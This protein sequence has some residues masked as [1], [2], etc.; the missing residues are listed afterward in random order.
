LPRKA[1]LGRPIASISAVRAS[2]LAR[3]R[4]YFKDE[5]LV[6]VGKTMVPLPLGLSHE[7]PVRDALLRLQAIT[8]VSPT[9]M[10]LLSVNRKVSI[11]CSDYVA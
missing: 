9:D 11:T 7:R 4:E 8:S 6:Q 5:L 3:L 10:N 1:S 2:V